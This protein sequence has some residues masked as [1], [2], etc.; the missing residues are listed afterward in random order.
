MLLLVIA[1]ALRIVILLVE[2]GIPLLL[3]HSLRVALVL[4]ILLAT[5]HQMR[6][7]S[8]VVPFTLKLLRIVPGLLVDIE[9]VLILN[10]IVVVLIILEILILVSHRESLELF[11]ERTLD[12]LV[13]NLLEHRLLSWHT[14]LYIVLRL[15]RLLPVREGLRRRLTYL[16][17]LQRLD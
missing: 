5:T 16:E 13:L 8:L 2:M 4:W 7:H 12:T 10:L 11:I 14:L 17:L 3:I 6:R 15:L 9:V 1:K